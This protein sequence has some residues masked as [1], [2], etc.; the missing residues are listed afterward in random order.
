MRGT[1]R[2]IQKE[3]CYIISL[4]TVD[5]I[6]YVVVSINMCYNSNLFYVP[7]LYFYV[8]ILLYLLSLK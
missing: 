5:I 8:I 2:E 4:H 6:L 7:Y 1:T 3:I